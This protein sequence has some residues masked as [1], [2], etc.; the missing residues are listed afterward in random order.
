MGLLDEM[1]PARANYVNASLHWL[2]PLGKGVVER[3]ASYVLEGKDEAVLT[4]IAAAKDPNHDLWAMYRERYQ[5]IGKLI[6][7]SQLDASGW[8]RFAR[9]LKAAA[10]GWQKNPPIPASRIE[11]AADQLAEVVNFYEIAGRRGVSMT[12]LIEALTAANYEESEARG[13]VLAFQ[14]RQL[15]ASKYNRVVVEGTNGLIDTEVDAVAM[16]LRSAQIEVRVTT[17]QLLILT[18]GALP[19]HNELLVTPPPS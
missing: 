9:V 8:V 11:A 5:V 6:S 12:F 4:E 17:L 2:K 13:G 19:Q 16:L 3:A 14:G 15:A 18:P 10:P 1:K 7:S